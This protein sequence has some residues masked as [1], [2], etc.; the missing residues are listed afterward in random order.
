MLTNIHPPKTAEDA[1]I[2]ASLPRNTDDPDIVEGTPEE[3]AH[4]DLLRLVRNFNIK[5]AFILETPEEKVL[6]TEFNQEVCTPT[7]WAQFQQRA[8]KNNFIGRAKF[9]SDQEKIVAQHMTHGAND[10]IPQYLR[11]IITQNT[12]RILASDTLCLSTKSTVFAVAPGNYKFGH[13]PCFHTDKYYPTTS[14]KTIKGGGLQYVI[15]KL[16]D[17]ERYLFQTAPRKFNAEISNDRVGIVAPGITAIFGLG[18]AHRSTTEVFEQGQL[19]I[20]TD[21]STVE[22]DFLPSTTTLEYLGQNVL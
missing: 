2:L 18:F 5:A 19:A 17:D 8:E 13:F 14:H 10:N 11:N 3:L 1:E 7:F 20:A 4:A 21:P 12:N 9:Y 6:R 16:S 22:L 15:G